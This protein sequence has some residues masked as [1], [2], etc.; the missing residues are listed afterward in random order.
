MH[1]NDIVAKNYKIQTK[2]GKGAFGEIWKAIHTKTHQE[3]AIK[4]EEINQRH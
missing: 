3:V 2:L 4:F 1:P